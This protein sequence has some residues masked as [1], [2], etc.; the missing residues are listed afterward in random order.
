[1]QTRVP[2]WVI[3]G[4]KR[5]PPLYRLATTSRRAIGI[6]RGPRHVGGLA[7]R[8]HP[9]DTMI[10]GADPVSVERYARTGKATIDQ[11]LALA[12][13]HVGPVEDL[14]WMELGCGYGRLIRHLKGRVP[15][16]QI[17]VTDVDRRG[18]DFCA[19]EFK[20]TG[21]A[22]DRPSDSL[23]F[24]PVD[25]LYAVSVISHLD[26]EDVDA[27]IRLIIRTL[28]P[29]GLALLST[30][31]P[32]TLEHLE[33]YGPGWPPMRGE[34]EAQ[35]AA[36]GWAFLQYPGVG[37]R[38][39]LTWHDPEWLMA[40]MREL[41]GAAVADVEVIPRGLEEHQDLYLVHRAG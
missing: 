13:T 7:D 10:D 17:T 19:S 15:A 32:S 27:L 20:V 11:F 34:I 24:P 33:A 9:N 38:Y 18:V 40:R 37:S 3:E 6:A 30:H 1:M 5:V 12:S 39:G 25:V 36:K 41:G 23:E 21:Y 8:V 16:D 28:R 2:R 22:T 14:R 4:V 35:L 31:G 26:G 29:G